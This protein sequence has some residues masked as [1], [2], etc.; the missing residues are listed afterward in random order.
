MQAKPTHHTTPHNA[1]TRQQNVHKRDPLTTE[2]ITRSTHTAPYRTIPHGI[3]ME[4]KIQ[5]VITPYLACQVRRGGAQ[6]TVGS[7]NVSY[8]S[9]VVMKMDGCCRMV[10]CIQHTWRKDSHEAVNQQLRQRQYF[11]CSSYCPHIISHAT[12]QTK[13][14][15]RCRLLMCWRALGSV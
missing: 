5:T 6:P 1:S 12:Q 4:R 9:F 2:R 7:E 13:Y 8:R 11:T 14:H 3:D 10:W 15:A